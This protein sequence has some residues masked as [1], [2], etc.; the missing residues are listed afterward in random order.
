MKPKLQL[1]S[2]TCLAIFVTSNLWPSDTLARI[3]DQVVYPAEDGNHDMENIQ[4]IVVVRVSKVD[5]ADPVR[6]TK[7]LKGRPPYVL[8]EE[9]T[10]QLEVARSKV[11]EKPEDLEET[12]MIECSVKAG[13]VYELKYTESG[14]ILEERKKK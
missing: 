2:I 4:S 7:N 12:E 13:S 11:F 9:G 10:H 1:L 8:L 14:I 3:S 5:G 6:E